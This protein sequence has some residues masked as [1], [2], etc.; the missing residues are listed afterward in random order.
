M[1][2]VLGWV[3]PFARLHYAASNASREL[4]GRLS[5]LEQHCST[6]L[7]CFTFLA[8]SMTATEVAAG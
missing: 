6:V 7:S 3:L 8:E 2:G 1:L 5:V 4:W